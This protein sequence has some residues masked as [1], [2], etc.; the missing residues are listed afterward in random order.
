MQTHTYMSLWFKALEKAGVDMV[1]GSQADE[2]NEDVYG[3]DEQLIP[4]QDRGSGEAMA[5]ENQGVGTT[6]Y[7]RTERAQVPRKKCF[8][9]NERKYLSREDWSHCHI[10]TQRLQSLNKSTIDDIDSPDLGCSS[11]SVEVPFW[12]LLRGCGSL[13]QPATLIGRM[14]MKS[15]TA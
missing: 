11:V 15:T 4:C 14:C 12:S 9:A 1:W 8:N 7:S 5:R 2:I 10:A 13:Q 6:H 3:G